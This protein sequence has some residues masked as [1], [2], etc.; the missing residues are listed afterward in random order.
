[1]KGQLLEKSGMKPIK[2]HYLIKE[3]N[4]GIKFHALPL[5]ARCIPIP[6]TARNAN[7]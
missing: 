7:T 6:G 1:M 2:G 3:R 5:R 4:P